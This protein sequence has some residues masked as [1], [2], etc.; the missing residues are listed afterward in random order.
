VITAK[1]TTENLAEVDLDGEPLERVVVDHADLVGGRE[2]VVHRVE[3]LGALRPGELAGLLAEDYALEGNRRCFS[4]GFLRRCYMRTTSLSLPGAGSRG[5]VRLLYAIWALVYDLTVACDPAYRGNA[6]RMVG[7]VVRDQDRV[8]DVGV[9]TG[10]LAEYGAPTASAYA[11]VDYSGS[12]L[13]KA[14]SKIARLKL[15]NVRLQ[16]A[17]A[18]S[19]PFGDQQF[20]TVVSSFVLPHFAR[21]EKVEILREMARVLVPGGRLGLFLAQGEVAPLFSTRPQLEQSLAEA[22]FTGVQIEDRDH[23]YRVVR[24]ELP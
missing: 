24:A 13:A 4:L 10:L 22:G 9:G 18:R 19:L 17:D 12:M 16:W 5:Y 14:A 3:A 2:L 21:E 20:D 7:S 15:G 1:G 8:L 6:R 23:V 11:G